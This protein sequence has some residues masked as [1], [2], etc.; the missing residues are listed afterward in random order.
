[1]ADVAQ[2]RRALAV[3]V[4]ATMIAVI[5]SHSRISS[6][7]LSCGTTPDSTKSSSQYADSSASS[8]T[9]PSLLTKSARDR[10]RREAR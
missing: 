1:M 4:E 10:A 2:S 9:M 6:T 5:S 7:S 3:R 8:S